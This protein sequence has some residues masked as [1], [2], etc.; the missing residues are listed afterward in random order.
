[1][2]DPI[3]GDVSASVQVPSLG[4]ALVANQQNEGEAKTETTDPEIAWSYGR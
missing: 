2:F 3:K 1:M 4:T